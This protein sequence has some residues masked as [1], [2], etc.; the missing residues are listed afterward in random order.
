MSIQ[1]FKKL[2]YHDVVWNRNQTLRCQSIFDKWVWMSLLYL[3]PFVLRNYLT[4]NLLKK[5]NR[6]IDI[7]SKRRILNYCAL[8][9]VAHLKVHTVNS[10]CVYIQDRWR[11]KVLDDKFKKSTFLMWLRNIQHILKAGISDHMWYFHQGFIF[12]ENRMGE[13]LTSSWW[14]KRFNHL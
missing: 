10:F 6:I 5:I 3:S 14:L 8:R 2:R 4:E 7:L 11:G 9:V 13:C 12:W 1:C